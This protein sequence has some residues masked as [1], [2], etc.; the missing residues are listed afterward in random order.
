MRHMTNQR[1]GRILTIGLAIAALAVV[2]TIACV[3]VADSDS[4]VCRADLIVGRGESCAYPGTSDEFSVGS[5]GK[6]RFLS[7]TATGL[8]NARNVT[9]NGRAYNFAARSQGGGRWRI[10]VAGH[11]ASAPRTPTPTP[12][13]ARTP[14]PTP[15]PLT[16]TDESTCRAGLTLGRGQSCTYP[17]TSDEFS[18]GSDGKGRFLSYTATGLLNARNVTIFGRAYNFA[19]RSQGGGRWRILVA[20][21]PASAPRTPTPIIRATGPCANGI[22]VLDPNGNPGLVDDCNTLLAARDALAGTASL[23]W[24]VDRPFEWWRGVAIGGSPKRV[25]ELRLRGTGLKG[26]IPPGLGNLA[27]LVVLDLSDNELTGEIPTELGNLVNLQGLHLAGNQLTGCIPAALRRVENNDLRDLGLNLC[28]SP[29]PTPATTRTPTPAPTP[30]TTRTPTPTPTPATT[31]TPTPTPTPVIRATGPCANGLA[32]QNPQQNPGLVS[33]CNTLLAAGDTL[34]GTASLD[35]NE[36]D[37]V[38]AAVFAAA[39][40]GTASLD[41]SEDRPIE[42]WQGVT[43]GGSPKRVTEL[44]L[45]QTGLMGGRIPPELGSLANLVSLDLSDNELAG[46]IP[47]ELASLNLHV[48]RLSWNQ[49][50]GQIPTELADLANLTQ[51]H[52]GY[53]QLTGRIPP[54]LGGLANLRGLSLNENQL[55]GEIPPEL[56]ALTRL[57]ELWLGGNELTGRIP[58]ELGNLTNLRDF[59]IQQSQ[60]TGEIPPELGNLTNLL[61]LWI[62]EGRLTGTIPPELGNLANLESLNLVHNQLTGQIPTE[63]GNLV[64]LE[65]LSLGGNQL[66][67]Q[68]PTELGN[69]VNLRGLSL[70]DNQL[71][72]QI[73]PELGNLVNLDSL[74]LAGN[75]LTGCIPA[76][77]RRVEH[78]DLRD[79]DLNICPSD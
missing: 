26:R 29:A 27:N 46:E 9:A 73:P 53:N 50:T 70:D 5:D 1:A 79:L 64:N 39:L 75:Q 4:E 56:G 59:Y 25:T 63:L 11:P 3:V 48:L 21:H 47:P 40:A 14:T 65:G 12:P 28:P 32:V 62:T 44:Y 34:A 22:A 30:A 24:S 76:A 10:L 61:Q 58:P 35:W 17:G 57:E 69:L 60:L 8:L 45:R 38:A 33:D 7:Y 19:A 74:Y 6:G 42:W 23:D 77:L 20:G 18:V 49:L 2:L 67:G 51:L 13:T 78:S 36:D 68:I 41:W 37:A 71:T 54:E 31:R 52:L 15:T 72:G 55:T 43:I 66:T 16:G